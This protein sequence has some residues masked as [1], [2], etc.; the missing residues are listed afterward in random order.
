MEGIDNKS[1][2]LKDKTTILKWKD[3]RKPT[4]QIRML[5]KYPF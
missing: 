4:A 3:V 1:M 2:K 5:A